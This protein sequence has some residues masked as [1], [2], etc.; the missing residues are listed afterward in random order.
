M[1]KA[2][3]GEN[4]VCVRKFVIKRTRLDKGRT[5]FETPL[6]TLRSA[7]L[8]ALVN[9]W[10]RVAPQ[11]VTA[12]TK[13]NEGTVIPCLILSRFDFPKPLVHHLLS[14]AIDEGFPMDKG[15]PEACPGLVHPCPP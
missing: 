15:V 3:R 5:R 2:A 11:R 9:S 6:S 13:K 7:P 14:S 12:H 4:P 8:N 10:T 1:D